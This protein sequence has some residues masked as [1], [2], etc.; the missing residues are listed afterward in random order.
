MCRLLNVILVMY[1]TL[2]LLAHNVLSEFESILC[3]DTSLACSFRAQKNKQS[4][5]EVTTD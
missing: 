1:R 3:Y 5:L 2:E 4:S